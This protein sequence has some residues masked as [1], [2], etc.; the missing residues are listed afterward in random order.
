MAFCEP[1]LTIS[2]DYCGAAL[3]HGG[4]QA[5][6]RLPGY[7]LPS[8]LEHF[9]KIASIRRLTDSDASIED[10]PKILNRIEVRTL[11]GPFK[12]S[13]FV[14]SHTLFGVL[15]AMF[16]IVILLENP[17]T[18]QVASSIRQHGSRNYFRVL[19]TIHYSFD[20]DQGTNLR[21]RETVP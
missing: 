12:F 2:F 20:F 17:A 18:V 21:A 3:W 15:R 4:D 13:D 9:Q 8:V 1:P 10:S 16:W 7:L 5:G 11:T 19:E 6:Q 14:A